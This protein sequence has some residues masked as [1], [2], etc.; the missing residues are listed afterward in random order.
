MSQAHK[1]THDGMNPSRAHLH[2]HTHTHTHTQDGTVSCYS[3]R[4]SGGVG[5]SVEQRVWKSRSTEQHQPSPDHA[6]WRAQSDP[7]RLPGTV[8][9]SS[10]IQTG[11]AQQ[12]ALMN[13]WT[14]AESNLL[15]HTRPLQVV[16]VHTHTHAHAHTLT[17]TQADTHTRTQADM[18]RID[19]YDQ[20]VQAQLATYLRSKN[21]ERTSSYGQSQ[22]NN[23]GA[24][25]IT[26]QVHCTASP[27]ITPQQPNPPPYKKKT[28]RAGQ[29]APNND[30]P[31]HQVRCL[32]SL[33]Q[34]NGRAREKESCRGGTGKHTQLRSESPIA[35]YSH[36]TTQAQ[37]RHDEMMQLKNK[38]KTE[39]AMAML[40]S[41]GVGYTPQATSSGYITAQPQ[42]TIE[43]NEVDDEYKGEDE[44]ED[45]THTVYAHATRTATV[46][47]HFA[48]F[49]EGFA[50]GELSLID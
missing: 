21:H 12:E 19:G 26:K 33:H 24:K 50:F 39:R 10:T 7:A 25:V 2:T 29:T 47:S 37:I 40:E 8:T 18:S 16:L 49:A 14:Q 28:G 23:W 5:R 15:L 48:F 27:H 6:V 46:Q 30:Q 20:K 36:C 13:A 11:D 38:H 22:Q 4:G 3:S 1:H 32:D 41:A 45:G 35:V 31:P 43:F 42:A 9:C 34:G 44:G 17:H